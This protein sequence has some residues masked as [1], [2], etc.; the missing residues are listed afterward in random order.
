[1]EYSLVLAYHLIPFTSYFLIPHT[2]LTLIP[3]GELNC[4]FTQLFN[5]TLCVLMYSTLW[6]DMISFGLPLLF[7]EGSLV[8]IFQYNPARNTHLRVY[9]V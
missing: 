1:M 5:F 9:D 2:Q 3:A 7:I 8:M 4:V 6:F